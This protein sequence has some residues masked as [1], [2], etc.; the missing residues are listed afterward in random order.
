MSVA[1]LQAVLPPGCRVSKPMTRTILSPVRGAHLAGL[2][3]SGSSRVWEIDQ[4]KDAYFELHA[5]DPL[6][7]RED[8]IFTRLGYIDVQHLPQRIEGRV[9]MA[10]G[11]MYTV[12]PPSTQFA[13]YNKIQ[14][15]KDLHVYPDF[16]HEALSGISDAIF[17]FMSEL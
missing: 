6:H 17:Q 15:D 3:G 10:V 13:A 7:R 1:G 14:A 9:M 5:F 12:C 11:L 16:G 8:E 4:A 2:P